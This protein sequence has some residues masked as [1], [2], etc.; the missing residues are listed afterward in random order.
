MVLTTLLILLLGSLL[1]ISLIFLFC[2]SLFC[3]LIQGVAFWYFRNVWFFRDPKRNAPTEKGIIV[4][5]ADGRVMYIKKVESNTIVSNKQG[6]SIEIKEISH[7][8]DLNI[9]EGWL[10]GI[11][12]TPFDVHFNY[13]P[14]DGFIQNIHHVKTDLNLPMVDLWEYINFTLL[15][16]A[17]NLFSRKF[18]FINERMTISIQGE[19]IA[20]HAILIADKFVNKIKKFVAVGDTTKISQK[21]SFI[22]RGSQVDLLIP[23]KEIEIKVRTGQQV[24]GGK[25]V[26]AKF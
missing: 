20:V 7:N 12:M 14:I 2:L 9:S 16:R 23:R 15:R 3:C 5:P 18:H 24:Y 25:S 19:L 21:L 17:V 6:E 22:G 13:S 10:I 8:K 1:N 11:Y 26:L 4:S